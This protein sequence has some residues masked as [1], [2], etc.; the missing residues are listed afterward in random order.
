MPVIPHPT[1]GYRWLLRG[2]GAE[3][4]MQKLVRNGKTKHSRKWEHEECPSV[5][6]AVNLLLRR[7]ISLSV[8]KAKWARKVTVVD[9]LS[10]GK[11][12]FPSGACGKERANVGDV[13][14][15][16]V[17]SLGWEDA[18][19]EGSN[20]L[21]YSCLQKPMDRGAWRAVVHRVTKNQTRLKWL[22]TH[23]QVGKRSK[24]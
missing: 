16:G 6:G 13:R 14:G 3:R 7:E 10:G 12:G 24:S 18:L 9:M 5:A 8:T 4:R 1:S 20:P 11:E 22:S 19:E 15:E 21:H 2:W 17:R 23:T